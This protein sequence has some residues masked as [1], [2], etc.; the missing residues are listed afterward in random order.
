MISNSLQQHVTEA[1]YCTSNAPFASQ[2]LQGE[3][4][5]LV[6]CSTAGRQ[7]G[8]DSMLGLQHLTKQ[9]SLVQHVLHRGIHCCKLMSDQLLTLALVRS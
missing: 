9:P 2:P 4:A 3:Q 5:L 1:L 7:M 8:S 6:H